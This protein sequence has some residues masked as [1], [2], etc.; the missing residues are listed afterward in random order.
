[1]KKLLTTFGLLAFGLI[2]FLLP[3]SA[4]AAGISVSGGYLEYPGDTSSV[5]IIA[6]GAT[7]N[8]FQG[9]ISTSGS[10]SITSCY[11]G[12]ALWV[13]KPTGTGSFAGALTGQVSSFRIATCYIS[14][15]YVGYGSVSVSG[16]QL[17]NSSGAY[18]GTSG[19]SKGF[20]ISRRP[21][22]P[23]TVTV[24]SSTHPNPKKAYEETTIK[25]NWNKPDRVTGFSYLLD[26]K[27]S[28]TPPSKVLSDE[29]AITYKDQKIGT[30]YFHIKA[31]NGDGWGPITHFKIKIKEPDPKVLNGLVGPHD[32][33][34][35]KS[36]EFSNDIENGKVS[37]IIISGITDPNYFANIA[38]SPLPDLP[39]GKLWTTQADET[40]KFEYLVD[41]P[42]PAGLYTLTVQGQDNKILTPLSEKIKFEI[43]QAKGG[44][45]NILTESDI[46][47]PVVP[48]P[49]WYEKVQ[50]KVSPEVSIGIYGFTALLLISALTG[51]IAFTI[52]HRSLK[53]FISSMQR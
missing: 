31:L 8:G 23:G 24:E 19:G 21:V 25:L 6:S 47:P 9:T 22:P 32:I 52:R 12:D 14:A 38:L 3:R 7:F 50:Q 11:A 26:K 41:F 29:T 45:L 40:G 20:T 35:V 34:I 44:S 5:A 16:V 18:V 4:F 27:A 17:T 10:I 51:S 48:D 13:S 36:S 49:K 2:L 33:T 43:S 37:G 15:N 28:T 1:M 39:E 46:L 53:K 30:Y 42:I